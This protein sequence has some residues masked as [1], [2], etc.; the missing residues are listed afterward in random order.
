ML[1]EARSTRLGKCGGRKGNRQPG[2]LEEGGIANGSE[3]SKQLERLRHPIN[4]PKKILILIR[5]VIIHGSC[6]LI[7]VTGV[8]H[9]SFIVPFC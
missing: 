7:I 2:H 8:I 4:R 9:D 5:G 1:Q 3:I 6:C